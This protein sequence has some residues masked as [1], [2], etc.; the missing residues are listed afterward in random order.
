VQP[1]DLYDLYAEGL[2]PGEQAVQGG[3]ILNRA[4]NERLDWLDR[5]AEPIKIEQG[6]GREDAAHPDFVVRRWHR[7]PQKLGIG[8]MKST[9]SSCPAAEGRGFTQAG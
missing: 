7:H 9:R 5:G 4:V 3:L 2:E 1:P 8:S 6:L